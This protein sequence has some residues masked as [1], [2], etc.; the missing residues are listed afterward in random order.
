LTWDAAKVVKL[1]EEVTRARAVGHYG[2]IRATRAKRVAQE[3]VI[4]LA[5]TRVE[6]DEAVRRVSL[7]E[8]ELVAVRRA[9]DIAEVKL[10]SLIDKATAANGWREE[11]E[12][13]C[14]HLVE[15]LT[16]LRLA[17][18]ELCLTIVGGP[19]QDPLYEGMWFTVA[20]YT[21]VVCST[22]QSVLGHLPTEVLQ[23][24]VM[25]EIVVKFRE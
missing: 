14:E 23:A 20:H 19:P 2:G 4:L 5:S 17:G 25:G 1:Q 9:R 22:A 15:E 18:F 8:G 12:E 13:Q 7:L 10:L 11:A 21:G 6:A 3:K 24:D 16:L